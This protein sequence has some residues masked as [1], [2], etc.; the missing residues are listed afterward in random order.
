MAD[1]MDVAEAGIIRLCRQKFDGQTEAASA[2]A[3][4]PLLRCTIR[5][6]V[7]RP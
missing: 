5:L 6:C 1:G 3:P 2:R 7:T 4:G